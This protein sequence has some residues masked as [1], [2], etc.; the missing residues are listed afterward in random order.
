[1]TEIPYIGAEKDRGEGR[2]MLTAQVGGPRHLRQ[3]WGK[4]GPPQKLAPTARA[5]H[6]NGA[7]GIPPRRLY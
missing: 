6:L 5:E 1:V 7:Q 4:P 3:T 2:S